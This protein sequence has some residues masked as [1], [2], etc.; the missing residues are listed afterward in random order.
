MREQARSHAKWIV[1]VQ[2]ILALLSIAVSF[3]FVKEDEKSIEFKIMLIHISFVLGPSSIL[4]GILLLLSYRN[5]SLIE[6]ISPL[7]FLTTMLSLGLIISTE[8]TGE[9]TSMHRYQFNFLI[10]FI[11]WTFAVFLGVTWQ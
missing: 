7:M 10:V 1:I 2:V 11:D 5:L 3:L 9:V 4:I 8:F 6:L